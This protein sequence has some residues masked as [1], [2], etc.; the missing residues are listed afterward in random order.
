MRRWHAIALTALTALAAA[1]PAAAGFDRARTCENA[2]GQFG[3]REVP[4][5]TVA[6][7]RAVKGYADPAF[8]ATRR[9]PETGLYWA[10]APVA[11]RKGKVVSVSIAREDRALADLSFYPTREGETDLRDVVR[12]SACPRGRGPGERLWS[13]WPGGFVLTGPGC[14]DLVARARGSRRVHRATLSFGM[15]EACSRPQE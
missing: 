13:S 2:V 7:I 8:F 4:V 1:E 9:D 5:G 6:A 11:V 10:K 3:R 14:V 15:G 12:F